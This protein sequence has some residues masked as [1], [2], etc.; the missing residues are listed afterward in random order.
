MHTQTCKFGP[1]LGR[2]SCIMKWKYVDKKSGT[3]NEKLEHSLSWLLLYD[4]AAGKD[5]WLG[6]LAVC[7]GSAILIYMSQK[8][9][10]HRSSF[11]EKKEKRQIISNVI[12]KH[13]QLRYENIVMVCYSL[14]ADLPKTSICH[15]RCQ[16]KWAICCLETVSAWCLDT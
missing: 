4:S 13:M 16:L 10:R 2:E 3:G 15:I 8:V 1:S 5:W 11:K 9:P 12:L 7:F 6:C 14:F